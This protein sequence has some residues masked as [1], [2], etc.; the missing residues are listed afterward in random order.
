MNGNYGTVTFE[1][2][3]Y[4][5]IQDAYVR[6]YARAVDAEGNEYEITWKQTE[7]WEEAKDLYKA[8]GEVIEHFYDESNAC[9][10]DKPIAVKKV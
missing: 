3:D 8:T 9:E 7:A 5:I 2:K 1:G 6:Y 4:R 10:W